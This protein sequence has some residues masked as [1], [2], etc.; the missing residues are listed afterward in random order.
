MT[1]R[2]N[3]ESLIKENTHCQ[4]CISE[5]DDGVF[6]LWTNYVVEDDSW[7]MV[8]VDSNPKNRFLSELI[9]LMFYKASDWIQSEDFRAYHKG[10]I[11]TP[12]EEQSDVQKNHFIFLENQSE[13]FFCE[14]HWA[15]E[16][17]EENDHASNM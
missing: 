4:L 2:S 10:A 6:L 7:D 3:W 8:D 1:I 13:V 12:V 14:D 16:G 11:R 5:D 9:P 15:S 17:G